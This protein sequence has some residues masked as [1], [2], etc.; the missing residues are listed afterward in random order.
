MSLPGLVGPL[1]AESSIDRYR[2]LGAFGKPAY[3]SHVQ[4]RAALLTRLGKPFANYFSRPTF[5]V[6]K[7]SL[8]WNAEVP[9]DSRRWDSLSDERRAALEPELGRIRDG[10][11]SYV[12]ELRA[13]AGGRRSG[14]QALASL[15]EQAMT[16][17]DD[18]HLHLIGDQPVLSF[19]GFEQQPAPTVG[20]T[21]SAAAGAATA[22][23]A[24]DPRLPT[25]PAP[26]AI[27]AGPSR[28]D[29]SGRR[30]FGWWLWLLLL[31]LL[32]LLWL[33][34]WL[35][36]S[37][38]LAGWFAHDGL[39]SSWLPK[40]RDCP[41]AVVEPP[42][43]EPIEQPPAKLEP[44]AREGPPVKEGA[45]AKVE[46]PAK[47]DPPTTE[48]AR[49]PIDASTGRMAIPDGAAQ[50]RDL[51]FLKGR[52]TLGPR[53]NIAL[54]DG[55]VTGQMDNALQ[56]D[57]N[58]RGRMES[59]RVGGGTCTAPAR[60]RFDGQ[61]LRIDTERCTGSQH[62]LVPQSMEC[63]RG[64]DGRTHCLAINRDPTFRGRP[65][66]RYETWLAEPR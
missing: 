61:V 58:G 3:Q 29:R 30:R 2:P 48:P 12:A 15:L 26:A 66:E 41:V 34:W 17:P 43:D 16:I 38:P 42:R 60:A 53:I 14:G 19:W 5:D 51:S 4:L 50:N 56:F 57:A 1:L 31:L 33:A 65:A 55:H 37:A 8:R 18:S 40:L 49:R 32:L 7:R 22:A 36:C 63:R 23:V 64:P 44:P 35:R 46:P 9:G 54:P 21:Q 6:E 10:L 62:D 13:S 20:A 39:A 27:A 47:T 25:A 59:R 11:R 28:E 24:A 45:P 52:W